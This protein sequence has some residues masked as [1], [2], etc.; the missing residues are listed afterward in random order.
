MSPAGKS[1]CMANRFRG[2]LLGTHGLEFTIVPNCRQKNMAGSVLSIF[3]VSREN[4]SWTKHGDVLGRVACLGPTKRTCGLRI[5]QKVERGTQHYLIFA[6]PQ[7][8]S[9]QNNILSLYMRF[10]YSDRRGWEKFKVIVGQKHRK[11]WSRH[12]ILLL[13]ILKTEQP[14]CYHSNEYK[15]NNCNSR[16]QTKQAKMSWWF[17]KRSR[18]FLNHF[19]VAITNTFSSLT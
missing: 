16:S 17:L 15:N 13:L 2:T 18:V 14:Q 5:N 1:N 4:S 9:R 6:E 12:F 7:I 19:S 3:F 10:L 8:R 11:R